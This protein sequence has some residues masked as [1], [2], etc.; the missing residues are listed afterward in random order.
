MHAAPGGPLRLLAE[1]PRMSAATIADIERRLGL[2][3]PLP[4]Q[5]ARWLWGVIR[6]DFG[7]SFVDKRPVIAMIWDAA[8]NTFWLSVGGTILGL[9][10]IPI[11]IYAARHRGKL[12][13]NVVR[14][15]T[16]ILN[17]VPHWWLGLLIIILVSNIAIG[18]GPKFLP[19]GQMYTIG[20]DNIIDRLWHM[21]LPAF[22]VSLTYIIV[23]TRFVRS[24]TLEVLNQDYVRTARAKG[25]SESVVSR[26]HV[27]RNSL[28][29]LIT[30]FGGVLPS[31]FS[32]LILI[33]SVLSWPGMGTLFI[34][35]ALQRDYPVLMG[36]ILFLSIL[37][38]LGN[39]LADLTYGLADPRVRYD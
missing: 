34:S 5:F 35:A 2:N 28:T 29:P 32:G 27:F 39:L 24:Q 37:I 1:D 9:L 15:I 25:M 14:I 38:V 21:I 36:V 7:Q 22:L 23:F 4:I 12:G 33:E 16:V 17:A 20:N 30:I 13:D 18:G 8:I 31:L 19:L 10:G 11:G 26:A 3:D 6:L